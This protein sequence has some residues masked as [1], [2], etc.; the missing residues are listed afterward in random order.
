MSSSPSTPTA[1]TSISELRSR[2]HRPPPLDHVESNEG[3]PPPAYPPTSDPRSTV[4]AGSSTNVQFPG[5][6]YLPAVKGTIRGIE[7]PR[8]HMRNSPSIST[9]RDDSSSNPP[10]SASTIQPSRSSQQDQQE[11]RDASPSPPPPSS[12]AIFRSDPTIKSCLTALKMDKADE[13]AKLFGV[14]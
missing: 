4:S 2:P 10:N 1:S 8:R 14:A 3:H 6:L 5:G 12:R 11:R 9:F 7:S 13:I